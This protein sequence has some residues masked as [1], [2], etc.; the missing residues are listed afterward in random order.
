M[1]YANI[2]DANLFYEIYGSELEFTEDG[3]REKPTIV[4]L[5]GGPGID[6]TFEVE[7]AKNYASHAQVIFLDHRG[8]GRSIED[9]PDKW[10]LNQWT[11]DVHS[12]CEALSI[13]QPYI[14]GV[15]MGGWIALQFAIKYPDYARGIILLD[16]EAY[17]DLERICAAYEKRGGKTISEIA[18]KFFQKNIPAPEIITQYFEKCLPL[19][20]NNPIPDVYFKR[21]ILRP[22]VGAHLQ[23]ERATFNYMRDL[24][25]IKNQVLYLTNTT[26]PAHLFDVAKETAAAM[27]NAKVTFVPFENCGIVQLDAKERAI[28][29]I[30]KFITLIN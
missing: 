28:E 10:N 4:V 11:R 23:L 14:Q 15:S 25:K 2:G 6:H 27:I 18:R 12:F 30:R 1:P 8:N 22:D 24:P 9:N 26:N 5:H 3:V 19:C 16:T 29:E 20:S 17:I 13:K 21:A 7:F